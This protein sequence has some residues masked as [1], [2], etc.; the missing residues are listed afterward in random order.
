[1]WWLYHL[2]VIG[3]Q[4]TALIC[5]AI[6]SYRFYK[7]KDKF[8]LFLTLGILFDII[9]AIG[10]SSG[11]LPRM[12]ESQGAPWSSPLFIVHVSFSGFGLF[13]FIFM[14][15]YLKIKGID[16]EYPKLRKF[17][18]KIMLPCW[19]TGV[20]ISLINFLIKVIFEIRLYDYI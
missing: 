20:S 10:A 6:G 13:S 18:F 8:M 9:M 14:Y 5:Y 19:I 16:Y 11:I 7:N 12:Q 15:V 1:M 3:L 2:W 4:V 17:Q